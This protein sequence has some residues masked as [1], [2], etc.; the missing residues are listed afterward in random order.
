MY[1]FSTRRYHYDSALDNC[2]IYVVRV[3]LIKINKNHISHF[4]KSNSENNKI[5][6][7]FCI[8]GCF[9]LPLGSIFRNIK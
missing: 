7:E 2:I 4:K 9:S 5:D 3:L 6:T 1:T 8:M